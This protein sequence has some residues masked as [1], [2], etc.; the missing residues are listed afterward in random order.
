M[1]PD[2]A[3]CDPHVAMLIIEDVYISELRELVDISSG[4]LS[5]SA[6]QIK[7]F[8]LV[9]MARRMQKLTPCTWNLLTSLM[10]G[11]GVCHIV[12]WVGLDKD[13]VSVD[14][15]QQNA[16]E[17]LGIR[18]AKKV[19]V[20]SLLMQFL[21]QKANFLQG[22]LGVF[23]HSSNASERIITTLAHIRVTVSLSSIHNI[24][25]SLSLKTEKSLLELGKTKGIAYAYDNFD[26]DIHRQI[27]TASNSSST[28]Q[29]FT[30]AI[31]FLLF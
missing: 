2:I 10:E 29:H 27:S 24:T 3:H 31:V 16:K 17:I 9:G 8:C 28:L 4:A 7:S 30:S 1:S 25:N 15:E 23:L 19:M 26:V 14:E 12:S 13:D 11:N 5:A 21:N 6:D 20:L 18:T 22:L